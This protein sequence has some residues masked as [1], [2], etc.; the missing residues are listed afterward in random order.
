MEI[1]GSLSADS[2]VN[3]TKGTVPFV[4]L[5]CKYDR[6]TL[7]QFQKLTANIHFH[8]IFEYYSP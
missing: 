4:Y 1:L 6:I 8:N 2:W 3:Y 7:E 5:L